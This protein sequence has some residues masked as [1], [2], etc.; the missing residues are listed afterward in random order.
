MQV[1]FDLAE[2]TADVDALGV[3]RLLD[4]IRTC[5]LDKTT[6]FYQA[7]TSE[8]YGKVQEIPQTETTPFYPRSPYGKHRKL[9]N[10]LKD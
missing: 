6:K 9:K 1:S 7:S 4:A 3:L 10:L 2:Y 8:L 5:N